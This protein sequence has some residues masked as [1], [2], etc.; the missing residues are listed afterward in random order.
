MHIV[1]INEHTYQW[2]SVVLRDIQSRSFW[3][4][5]LE[6]TGLDFHNERVIQFGAVAV[7]RGV[8]DPSATFTCV[9][10]PDATIPE[11][12]E[13]MTGVT[14]ERVRHAPKFPEAFSHFLSRAGERIWITQ[15][16]Y[17]F[18][19]PLLVGEC[20]RHGLTFPNVCILDTKG[21]L[22]SFTAIGPKSLI[23]IFSCGITRLIPAEREGMMH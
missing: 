2:S 5:D 1:D 4:F 10:D 22:H 23:P 8:L 18:D 7:E 19:C 15:A 20:E 14:N 6:A 11:Q 21:C 16:G 17:E 3:V 9:V 12:I 13:Q